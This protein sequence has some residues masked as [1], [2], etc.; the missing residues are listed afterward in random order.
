ME[1]CQVAA[2]DKKPTATIN[3]PTVATCLLT[4]CNFALGGRN[5]RYRQIQTKNTPTAYPAANAKPDNKP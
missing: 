4:R 5:S 2:R 3:T 1:F